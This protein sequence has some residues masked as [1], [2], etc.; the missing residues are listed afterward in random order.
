MAIL[1]VMA[2]TEALEVVVEVEARFLA[3]V[4]VA[5]IMIEVVTEVVGVAAVPKTA[6]ATT[7]LIE[8]I[9]LYFLKLRTIYFHSG[10]L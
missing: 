3:V 9:I 7:T 6:A 4:E 10:D 5:K 2:A 8:V 1:K